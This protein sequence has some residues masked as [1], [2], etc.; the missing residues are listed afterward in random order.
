MQQRKLLD[1]DRIKYK[2][3]TKEQ[4]NILRKTHENIE[5]NQGKLEEKE[6]IS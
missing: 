4:E 2:E 6:Y 5:T 3:S 1:N